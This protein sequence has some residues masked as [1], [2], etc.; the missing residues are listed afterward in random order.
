[1]LKK[2]MICAIPA[3]GL[4]IGGCNAQAGIVIGAVATGLAGGIAEVIELIVD[5][6]QAI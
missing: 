5:G 6:I 2:A 4:L 3:L 1:M